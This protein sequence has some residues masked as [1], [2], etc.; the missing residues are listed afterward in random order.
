M[1]L[2]WLNVLLIV[3][4]AYYEYNRGDGQISDVLMTTDNPEFDCGTSMCPMCDPTLFGN[5]QLTCTGVIGAAQSV[6]NQGSPRPEYTTSPRYK[7]GNSLYNLA[8]A[9]IDKVG[10]ECTN[11]QVLGVY[12][13]TGI[14][15]DSRNGNNNNAKRAQ[16]T[17]LIMNDMTNASLWI[18]ALHKI[19]GSAGSLGGA[20][21]AWNNGVSSLNVY[22]SPGQ[23]NVIFPD[24]ASAV[25]TQSAMQKVLY[26]VAHGDLYGTQDGDSLLGVRKGNKD[27]SNGWPVCFNIANATQFKEQTTPLKLKGGQRV[28]GVAVTRNQFGPGTYNVLAHVPKTTD[29][30][31]GGRG[32]VFAA[33]TFHA[34]EIYQSK[35]NQPQPKQYHSFKQ[36]PCFGECDGGSHSETGSLAC[37]NDPDDP[38]QSCGTDGEGESK[39]L[40]TDTFSSINHEIDI[41]IPNNSP[42]MCAN[43][44]NSSCGLDT[45]NCNTWQSDNGNY[46]ADTGSYYTQVAVKRQGGDFVAPRAESSDTREYHWYTI[47]WHVDSE[48]STGNYVKFYFDSPFDP[49]GKA[50]DP[51]GAMLPTTPS[52]PAIHSTH[53]FV[54]TRSGRFNF[55]PWFGWWGYNGNNGGTPNFHTANV[56]MAHLSIIP[57]VNH[58][59]LDYPQNYDQAGTE[60]DFRDI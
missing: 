30:S 49:T 6:Q 23:E 1:Q 34:E 7:F 42:Q 59:P 28:G 11:P 29:N 44:W 18:Q 55:G 39:Y 47:D 41:E 25:Q 27:A 43:D 3:I 14:C 17:P 22:V 21:E 37:P 46:V 52:S 10:T 60:C 5:S 31:T 26:T 35:K 24:P 50:L 20:L 16:T 57:Q 38:K 9:E 48:D 4:V 13:S 33:W 19:W 58:V 40:V 56:R 12:D 54:P 53:R 45:M 51:S 8:L 2:K 32:Y 36:F 15:H